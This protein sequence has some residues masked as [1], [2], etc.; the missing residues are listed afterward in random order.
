MLMSGDDDE[1]GWTMMM[2]SGD[3]DV[4][5]AERNGTERR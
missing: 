4:E 2:M 5:M 3:D 1:E